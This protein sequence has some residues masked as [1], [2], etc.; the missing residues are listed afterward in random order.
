MTTN[1]DLSNIKKYL[2]WISSNQ[3][4]ESEPAAIFYK[5]STFENVR[6]SWEGEEL[7]TTRKV[8]AKP[9]EVEEE[10]VE[11]EAHQE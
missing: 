1:T 3:R 7:T 4:R 8:V 2:T 10:W 9:T 6:E 5:G 11:A